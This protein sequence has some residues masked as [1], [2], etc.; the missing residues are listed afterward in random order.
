MKKQVKIDFVMSLALVL[1]V[2]SGIT[3]LSM[4]QLL[5][6]SN[7]S[8]NPQSLV[9]GSSTMSSQKMQK[10]N[11]RTQGIAGSLNWSTFFGGSSNDVV[12]D[13]VIDSEGNIV[14]GG[15][16]ASDDFPLKNALDNTFNN[17]YE[18]FVA[19]FSSSGNLLWS[20][21]LGGTESS[22]FEVVY[23]VT[24][25]SDN[26]IIVVGK[27][28]ASDFPTKNA[29]DNTLNGGSDGF[30]TKLDPDGNM[31][32]STYFGG[33]DIDIF[34]DVAVDNND[35]IIIS[36]QTYS[37]DFPEK[38]D[39]QNYLK[40]IS[41]AVLVKFSS[42]GVLLASTYVG[43]FNYDTGKSI[44]VD[45]NN[46]YILIGDTGSNDFP[47]GGSG[48]DLVHNAFGNST[49]SDGFVL[50]LNSQ[51]LPQW[52]TYVGG[53]DNDI[54]EDVTI[55]IQGD[56]YLTGYTGST[57][58]PMENGQNLMFLG[59]T[60]GFVI[61]LNPDGGLTW[62]RLVGGT[63]IDYVYGMVHDSKNHNIIVTGYTR[64]SNFPTM[65]P[66]DDTLDGLSDSFLTI[67][68]EQGTM[69]WST[70]I[71]GTSS[72]TG[73]ELAITSNGEKIL[74]VGITSSDDFPLLNPYENSLGGNEGT[75]SLFI[76][77]MSDLDDDGLSLQDEESLGLNPNA[78]DTDGDGMPD[79]WELQNDLN[80]TDSSDANGDKDGDG[81]P[82]AW[83][84]QH[85]FNAS[86]PSDVTGDADGDGLKN[87]V[88][89][90][91]GTDPQD[92]DTD[93]DWLFDGDEVYLYGTNATDAD[94]DDDGVSDGTEVL[95]DHTNP[96]ESGTNDNNSNSGS[97]DTN[98]TDGSSFPVDLP[99]LAAIVGVSA[100]TLII[101]GFL[102]GRRG[103]NK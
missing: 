11:L 43:G 7:G 33:S 80:A 70:Y 53:S 30:I 78:A 82:N 74:I 46:N 26:N 87:G 100:L 19:K 28:T 25:D 72:D 62:S 75:I 38:N 51:F 21:Y 57:D 84:Y 31:L 45:V 16:T 64:S 66:Q 13:T 32:W 76:N 69:T 50:K 10:G 102:L 27:T 73:N 55:G 97:E 18:A 12:E 101:F 37:D 68:D 61:K 24:I 71:G 23:G 3:A 83:E 49:S 88:E 22:G 85:G 86:D 77:P 54:I 60:D 41:D 99:V 81:M 40:G 47:V 92:P 8:S 29:Y 91:L 89:Y 79:G 9:V 6:E 4:S 20:T 35:S 36:G 52:G 42:E 44:S 17:L 2:I 34:F 90:F 39:I 15:Y 103:K 63:D 93:D 96:L 98:G 95:V 59:W 56:I 1:V 5:I 65:N 58:F 94:T 67:M 14:V 48:F